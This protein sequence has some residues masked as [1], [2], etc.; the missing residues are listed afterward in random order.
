MHSHAFQS[1]PL[2]LRYFIYGALKV[3]I[4]FLFLSRQAL[5]YLLLYCRNIY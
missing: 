5:H 4:E 1:P 3:T 2:F